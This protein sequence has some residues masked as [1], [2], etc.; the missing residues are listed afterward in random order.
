MVNIY[1]DQ[2]KQMLESNSSLD[3]FFI[4]DSDGNFLLQGRGTEERI[5]NRKRPL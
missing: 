1:E 5:R 4:I 3:Q 2:L